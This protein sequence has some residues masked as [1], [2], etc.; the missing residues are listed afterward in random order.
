PSA[1]TPAARPEARLPRP[2]ALHDALPAGEIVRDRDVG[3]ALECGGHLLGAP[4]VDLEDEPAVEDAARCLDE[5]ERLTSV[6]EG[7]ARLVVELRLKLLARQDVRRVGDD[8]VERPLD[9]VEEVCHTG[10][11][12]E[13][14]RGGIL[15]SQRDRVRRA[16]GRQHGRVGPLVFDR[17][18][19]RAGAGADVENLRRRDALDSRERALGDDL[20]LRPRHERPRVRGERQPPEAPLP[21]DVGKRLTAAPALHENA[22]L[23]PLLVGERAVVLRVEL[24]AREPERVREQELRVDPR[25][26][27]AL[28]LEVVGCRAQHLAE[29]HCPSARRRSSA[30][31][32]SVTSSRSPPSTSSSRALTPTRWSVTRSCGKLYVRIFSARSP[33]PTCALRAAACSACW[34]SRSASKSR[35][36]STRIAL[37]RFWSCDRSSCIATTMPVGRCVIR[38]AESVV[39]TDCPPGPEERKT[40]IFRSFSSTSTSTSSA[41]GMTATVAVDVWMRP[42]DS[43]TGTRW[44]RCVPPSYLKTE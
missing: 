32:A 16:V 21:Q 19:D 12:L 43:V 31:S 24:D 9:P 39:F 38:T 36:R 34:R 27:D 40:S 2:P 35:A 44:T 14:E 30:V 37:S 15:A 10:L 20:R 3:V 7:L 13:L 26:V 1:A 29:A 8:E 17:E 6:D 5:S 18:R 22:G 4:L 42:C 41:S 25:G 33:R 23:G 28:S 11:D